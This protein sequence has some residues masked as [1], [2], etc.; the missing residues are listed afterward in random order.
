M[1]W[2]WLP[3]APAG[4]DTLM[5]AR[6]VFDAHGAQTLRISCDGRYIAWLDG[7]ELGRGPVRSEPRDLSF[8]PYTVSLGEGPHVL[9]VL[10]RHYGR[11]TLYWKPGATQHGGLFI[12]G[13]VRGVDGW[14]VRRA[15]LTPQDPAPHEGAPDPEVIDGRAWP[16]AWLDAGYDDSTWQ[17]AVEI[18]GPALSRERPIPQLR[19]TMLDLG[20]IELMPGGAQTLD[21]GTITN[22]HVSLAVSAPAG[23]AIEVR[24]GEEA[25]GDEVL[26]DVRDWSLRYTAA[27]L[28]DEN[29]E[30]FEPIGF[31]YVRVCSSEAARVVVQAR[32]RVF[33]RTEGAF[34]DCSDP[35]LVDIWRAGVRTLELCSTDA[36]I[37]C[38]S[39]EQRAWLGDDYVNT[40][41]SLVSNPDTSLVVHDLRL[42]A[43]G[44]RADG[45]L[46]MVA[47]GDFTDRAHTIPD[48]SLLWVSTLARTFEHTGDVSMVGE[49][50]PVVRR[51]LD[52]FE[53]M[54]APDGLL[55]GF[56]HG[57][58]GWVFVDWAQIERGD[59]IAAVDTMYAMAL[60]D[61]AMMVEAIGED[62]TEMRARHA[63]TRTAFEQLWDEKRGAYL[64]AA[65]LDGR[66]GRR[67]SQHTN[68][69]AICGEL[70]PDERIG[71]VLDRI[72]DG[73]RLV[74]TL[75]PGDGG[76]LG[77]RLNRQWEQ[78]PN[79]DEEEDVVL[80]QPFFTHFVHRALVRAGRHD[81]LVPSMRRWD[82]MVSHNG[83]VEEYWTALPG[84]GSRCHSWSGT[85]TYDL[86]AHVVGARPT[87]PG[88]TEFSV[89]PHL[90]PLAWAEARIPTPR[91]WLHVR[92]ESG[93]APEVELT[94]AGDQGN[95]SSTK[96]GR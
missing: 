47:A 59:H 76:T 4:I 92:A 87:S 21:L 57:I 89:E 39:R 56:K 33:P 69:G 13:V 67:I 81:A 28:D 27:G 32:E 66:R 44:Q 41:V 55:A 65:W 50:L 70:V 90:G 43:A 51:I 23:G 45:L 78:P 40:L 84:F 6:H 16:V 1:S 91:G 49:L 72:T 94:P 75:T 2:I 62:P 3:D 20:T 35:A 95:G 29:V 48:Y 19:S 24:C 5:F 68:S 54:R 46:P 30:A 8:D 36:F 11:P 52:T 15:P 26:L 96:R 82:E 86:I 7:V 63:A 12:D 31:R 37:D 18:D 9:C 53:S 64:D 17:A 38:P 22:A 71:R 77:E 74:R 93:R 61:A 60:L 80:A 79:F 10:A 85:P 73:A 42:G 83:L 58:E 25:D 14:R 34:F 88:W